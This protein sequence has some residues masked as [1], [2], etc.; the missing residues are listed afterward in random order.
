MRKLMKT[1]S[2]ILFSSAVTSEPV[3]VHNFIVD[4][5]GTWQL[6]LPTLVF[7]DDLPQL[8]MTHERALCLTNAMDLDELA[9]H[10][11]TIH[12]NRRQ[13]GLIFVGNAGHKKLLNKVARLV[14]TILTSNCPIFMP[15]SYSDDLKLRLDSN[16]IFYW[17]NGPAKYKLF[18]IFA[19]KGGPPIWIELGDWSMQGGIMLNHSKNRWDR[20][21]DLEGAIFVNSV[22]NNGLWAKVNKDGNGNI[23]GSS[24]YFQ[25]KLFCI[26]D[27]LNL[28]LHTKEIPKEE[29]KLLENGSWTGGIGLLQRKEVDICS[30]G[31]G[32]TVKRNSVI[33]YP[34][35][36]LRDKITLIA[37]R[38]KG[39]TVNMWVYIEVFGAIQWAIFAAL[40][41]TFIMIMTIFSISSHEEEGLPRMNF[42]LSTIGTAYL[43]TIQQGNHCN[44]NQ[45]GGRILMLTVSMLTLLMFTYYTT[46]ITAKMTSVTPEIPIRTFEDVMDQGYKVIVSTAFYK[47]IL[48]ESEQ[49]RAKYKVYKKY[50]ENERVRD[51]ENEA[52]KEVISGEKTLWYSTYL[53]MV[54]DSPKRKLLLDQ[55]VALKMDDSLFGLTSFG[56][57]NNSEFLEIFNHFILKEFEHGILNRLYR[58]YN[59][60]LYVKEQFGMSE[61]QPLGY[62]NVIFAFACVGIG[63]VASMCIAIVESMVMRMSHNQAQIT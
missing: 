60:A 30:V 16:I 17:K 59:M 3:A 22:M 21:T 36:T 41:V 52:L 37:S 46:D 10:L 40:L 48:A 39:T 33:D 13:D 54:P 38:P 51:K 42:A 28:T 19:V 57:Q 7:E 43:L 62:Q 58:K 25:D 34:I 31:L 53:E 20:R 8:C 47:I 15:H 23:F 1:F 49:E 9:E 4:I 27:R 26:T 24:G 50:I 14:P 11:A 12:L 5:I 55:V 29:W 6:R 45:L 44:V 56:L 61:P 2:C 18:D 63:V 35:A 32:V